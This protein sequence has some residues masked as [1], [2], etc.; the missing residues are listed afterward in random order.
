MTE[1]L[2]KEV[3][4]LQCT[5]GKVRQLLVE[6]L[7]LDSKSIKFEFVYPKGK[8]EEQNNRLR[9]IVLKLLRLKDKE[10]I[11]KRGNKL[12]GTRIF[13]NEDFTEN[14]K[15]KRMELRPKLKEA[16]ES[17]QIAFLRYDQLI[18]HQPRSI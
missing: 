6:K 13:L 16:R 18:G 17:G 4:L 9:P 15:R 11:L 14:V 7:E 8:Y 10:E 1:S 2:K 5:E 12:R 3:S